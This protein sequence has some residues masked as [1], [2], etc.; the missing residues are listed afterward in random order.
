MATANPVNALLT[1]AEP[2]GRLQVDAILDALRQHLGMEI[3]FAARYLRDDG[4]ITRRQFTHLSSDLPLPAGPGDIE[5]ADQSFCWH[6]LEGR[7]PE[8]IH[9]A[10]DLAFAQTVPITAALPVGCHISVPIR[11]KDGSVYG[12]FCC[13]SRSSDYTLND[14][15]LRTVRAFAD[16]AR[17]QIEADLIG[18]ASRNALI[19]RIDQALATGQPVIH[20]Q[21][22]HCLTSSA[23]VGAE[24]L[25][26]F[27]DARSRP[28]NLWFDEAFAVG[29]GIELELAAVR[30]ALAGARQLPASHYVSINASPETLL[31]GRL[32]ELLA[33]AGRGNL[34]VEVTEHARVASYE[35]LSEQL[36]ALRPYARIAVD[37]VGAGYS[38]L[39]HILALEPDILKLDMSLT[40]DIDRD[41]ARRALVLAMV[42]FAGRIG[43]TL[44]AEGVES[45]DEQAALRDLGVEYGQ[46][47][48]FSRPMPLVAAQ[49]LLMGVAQQS[50]PP[51]AEA[52][53]PRA[54]RRA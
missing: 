18:E 21:P 36:A 41:P 31:S 22:I 40:R 42:S 8:L 4:Q 54:A 19:G 32:G 13:L 43:A 44:V 53:V 39:R 10:Q 25:A 5:P 7:L 50:E 26:R 1:P 17:D 48:R 28:P 46:G 34:V 51:A 2:G 30:Q 27:P 3:A 16:L 37:D 23:P 38:G 33:G 47:F 24:A 52:V 9:N 15:D 12:S 11:L 6:I 20:F 14:R 49:Q 29:R 45:E 35:A